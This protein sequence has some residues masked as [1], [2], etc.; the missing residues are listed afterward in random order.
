M[1]NS[2]II[3]G[4]YEFFISWNSTILTK[5][6]VCCII[7]FK[8]FVEF[9]EKSKEEQKMIISFTGHSFVSSTDQI[10]E[11]VKEQIRNQIIDGGVITCYLG[12]YGNFDEICAHA[13]RE[14]KNEYK[15]I[16]LI[17]VTPYLTLTEQTKIKQMQA[18]GLCDASIYPPIENTPPRFAISKRNEWMMANADLVIAYVYR[19]FGG[20]Y[21]SLQI[22]KRR[23]KKII[24]ICDYLNL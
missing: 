17:Y 4:K 8:E 11:I 9:H 12:G 3:I 22:A 5:L 10:K 1:W 18:Y 15:N 14:L 19:N 16:Q 24:N 13:C 21:H 6:P 20:A 2:T 7:I 23:K